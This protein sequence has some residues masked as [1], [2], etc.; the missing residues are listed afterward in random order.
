ML[1]WSEYRRF[2]TVRNLRSL[3][4]KWWNADVFFIDENKKWAPLFEEK[5]FY[6]KALSVFL[7]NEAITE[8]L[9]KFLYEKT[10]Q[11]K[12][13]QLLHFEKT[14]LS[15]LAVPIFKESHW[16][17]LL[18]VTG[19]V[20][21][22]EQ[23]EKTKPLLKNHNIE[24]TD[25]KILDKKELFYLEEIASSLASEFLFALESKKQS[26]VHLKK[27]SHSS[28]S[29]MIGKSP[30]MKNL[31][32]LLE[33]IKNTD[34]SVLIQG[35]N[36]TGKELIARAIYQ[37]SKRNKESFVAQN[38]S[39]L[40]DNLLESELF[41]HVKGAFT[42]AVQNKK[43]LFELADGG[44]LFLDE[45]GDTSLAMQAKLLRVLQDGEF[46]PVGSVKTKKV[47]V[48]VITATNKNLRSMM[49]NK[50]F[51]EDLYYRL[52]VINIKAPALRERKEDIPLLVEYFMLKE[53][54][55]NKKILDAGIMNHFMAYPWPGNVRE[56]QN[57][58]QRLAVLS[59][60]KTY[61]SPELLSEKLTAKS[62][63]ADKKEG[64][65]DA[66]KQLEE[67]MISRCLKEEN[68]N[69]T[70]VAKKLGISRAALISKVK[71]YD[72]ERKNIA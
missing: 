23:K 1:N 68:W 28:Y 25:I 50:T 40:N 71:I 5:Y 45:V 21:T 55:E 14:G 60:S 8:E 52:N 4:G 7:K 31:Y 3:L 29:G 46:F 11:S 19:F 44:T 64:L 37:N 32:L 12:Q 42:G 9:E 34:S 6:N 26:E 39:A 13:T 59:Q 72:L 58:I 62:P 2:H 30:M 22:S 10:A 48:R 53:S 61:V 41:G 35:E 16:A 63:G 15:I 36:G 33:K 49:E 56:L 20:E 70:R 27:L 24:D 51:R 65:K 69:K 57:E 54:K 43:G 67:Q 47:N 38:C 18:G 17:G 66:I